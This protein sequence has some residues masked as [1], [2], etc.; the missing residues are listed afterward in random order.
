MPV[1]DRIL[2]WRSTLP[3]L[4]GQRCRILERVTINACCIEFGDGEGHIV[5]RFALKKG[6]L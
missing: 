2:N 3:H 5:S 1:F 4:K 6:R